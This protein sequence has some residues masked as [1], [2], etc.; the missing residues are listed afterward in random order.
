MAWS[1]LADAVVRWRWRECSP[2]IAD[3]AQCFMPATA[4][5]CAEVTKYITKPFDLRDPGLAREL[6]LSLDSRHCIR[7]FGTWR[8]WMTDA[9]RLADQELDNERPERELS[10]TPFS[11]VC[12]AVLVLERWRRDFPDLAAAGVQPACAGKVLVVFRDREVVVDAEEILGGVRACGGTFRARDRRARL[13]LAS[14]GGD[15][16]RGEKWLRDYM[17]SAVELTGLGL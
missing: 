14:E 17:R 13:A 6:F 16:E 4:A 1:E 8:Q 9:E 12:E 3:G 5:K 11:H 10:R 2:E 15:Q 7:A